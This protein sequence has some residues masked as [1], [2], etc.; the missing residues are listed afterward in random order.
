[1]ISPHCP[2]S[3]NEHYSIRETGILLLQV[4]EKMTG[5]GDSTQVNDSPSSWYTDILVLTT[6]TYLFRQLSVKCSHQL[7][8]RFDVWM[9]FWTRVQP[10]QTMILGCY[11]KCIVFV[12]IAFYIRPLDE[13]SDERST[14]SIYWKHVYSHRH[15]GEI[16]FSAL[17]VLSC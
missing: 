12:G 5:H 4:C 17:S 8:I 7:I 11:Q 2:P 9:N 14:V 16:L 10:V 1:M 13:L 15:D 3:C 6:H